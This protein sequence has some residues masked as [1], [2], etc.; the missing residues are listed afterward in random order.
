MDFPFWDVDLHAHGVQDS[1]VAYRRQN[2]YTTIADIAIL[3]GLDCRT[4]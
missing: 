2:R 1:S 3:K 4:H